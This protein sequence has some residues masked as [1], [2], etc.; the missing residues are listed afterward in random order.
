MRVGRRPHMVSFRRRCYNMCTQRPPHNYSERLYEAHG[1]VR[2]HV[3]PLFGMATC[4]RGV[5]LTSA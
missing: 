4:A 5:Y 1:E 3:Q 2:S